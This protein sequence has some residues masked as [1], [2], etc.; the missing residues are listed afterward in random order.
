M[1]FL[2]MIYV[3]PYR[4]QVDITTS[5]CT[6]ATVYVDSAFRSLLKISEV[7]WVI[8]IYV[9]IYIYIYLYTRIYLYIYIYIYY[10]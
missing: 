10:D 3:L 5:R 2:L 9:Y 6:L 1:V 8:Y 4:C 7:F